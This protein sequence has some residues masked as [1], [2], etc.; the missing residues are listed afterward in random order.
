MIQIGEGMKYLHEKNI[1]HR[2]LA[3]R[4]VLIN[5]DED[6][7]IAKISDF[8]LSRETNSSYYTIENSKNVPIRWTAPEVFKFSKY[9]QGSDVWSYGV[10]CWEIMMDGERPYSLYTNELV[11]QKVGSGEILSQEGVIS[12]GL[13]T[14]LKKC[15]IKDHRERPNIE[16][17]IAEFRL[18]L[19]MKETDKQTDSRYMKFDQILQSIEEKNKIIITEIE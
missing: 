14:I 12:D 9:F 6:K 8:G 7:S 1:L 10:T 11:I 4:N 2:D 3:T 13:Y 18:Y 19:K 17:L 15:W 5:F 16:K